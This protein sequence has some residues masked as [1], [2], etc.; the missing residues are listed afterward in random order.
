MRYTLVLLAL[1]L[2]GCATTRLEWKAGAGNISDASE[3]CL[4]SVAHVQPG[5]FG[6]RRERALRKPASKP[7][8]KNAS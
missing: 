1:I 5:K 2:S 6:D 7:S 4:E 8:R 3:S